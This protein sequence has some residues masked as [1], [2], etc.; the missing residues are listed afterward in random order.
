MK[1]VRPNIKTIILHTGKKLLA[2]EGLPEIHYELHI[3]PNGE[4]LCWWDSE[5]NAYDGIDL[6][7]RC[8]L[9][10]FL[11]DCGEEVAKGLV[12]ADYMDTNGGSSSQFIGYVNYIES[13]IPVC[14]TALD[15]LRSLLTSEDVAGN[16]LL[17]LEK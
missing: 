16:C 2:V 8:E 5:Q 17:I 3:S 15:S 13:S 4:I 12:E 1:E 10:G 14:D 6:P 11:N 9:V 7:F